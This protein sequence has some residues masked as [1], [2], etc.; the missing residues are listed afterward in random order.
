VTTADRLCAAICR[1]PL[2]GS[3]TGAARSPDQRKWEAAR[4]SG[5]DALAAG[6]VGSDA[7]IVL[8]D[9]RQRKIV[10]A[11]EL[12]EADYRPWKGRDLAAWTSLVM[13]RG[14]VQRV[15]RQDL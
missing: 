2:P 1:C 10:S 11:A 5:A 4:N 12:H 6:R 15:H 8:L 14:K 7:D 3:E 9:P 13:L